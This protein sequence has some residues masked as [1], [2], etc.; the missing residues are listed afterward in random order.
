[1][2]REQ[3]IEIARLCARQSYLASTKDVATVLWRMALE[4]WEKAAK[5]DSGKLV[6][7]VQQ[8]P[9]VSFRRCMKVDSDGAA[10]QLAASSPGRSD[11]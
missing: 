10:L 9:N 7:R 4:H 3:L 11:C 5:L 8:L 2:T 6:G 1:M